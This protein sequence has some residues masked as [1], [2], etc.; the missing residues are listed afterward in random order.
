MKK[1]PNDSTTPRS[2]H[3]L[4]LFEAKLSVKQHVLFHNGGWYY[5]IT[6]PEINFTCLLLSSLKFVRQLTYL[7]QCFIPLRG[8]TTDQLDIKTKHL[9]CKFPNLG[10]T[11]L[12]GHFRFRAFF[13]LL[14]IQKG[15]NLFSYNVHWSQRS[16]PYTPNL[17]FKL[18]LS[19][20]TSRREFKSCVQNIHVVA[21]HSGNN[22]ECARWL[23]CTYGKRSVASLIL[24]T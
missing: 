17:V 22:F 15:W 21:S 2:W 5:Y 13:S 10:P 11:H 1:N 9:C 20:P 8:L 7:L 23:V 19:N 14:I 6:V 4:L 12:C 16:Y 18:W 3:F 24:P